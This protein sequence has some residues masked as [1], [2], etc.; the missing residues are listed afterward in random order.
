MTLGIWT[1]RV[2]V[3][4]HTLCIQVKGRV[5]AVRPC[6][7]RTGRFQFNGSDLPWFRREVRLSKSHESRWHFLTVPFLCFAIITLNQPTAPE[8]VS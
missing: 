1:P 6:N 2:W 5:L 7:D 3:A 4:D 8:T